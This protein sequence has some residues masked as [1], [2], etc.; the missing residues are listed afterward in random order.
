MK[1][2][3]SIAKRFLISGKFQTFMIVLGI[4]IGVSVQ[5][6][7]GSL[8]SGLQKSLVDKTI[9]SSSQIT[10]VSASPLSFISDYDEKIATIKSLDQPIDAI[11]PA[12][13]ASGSL[14]KNMI[15]NP[16]LIRGFDLTAAEEIYGFNEKLLLG[17]SLPDATGEIVVGIG[18]RDSLDLSIGDTI[19]FGSE[20][21][22]STSLEIVGFMDFNVLQLNSLWGIA[23]L[24][25]MQGI[26]GIGNQ[27]SKIEMQVSDV[28]AA[29]EID[30]AIMTALN[31]DSLESQNWKAQNAELLS[32]LQGQS[33]SSIMIQVFVM[34]SV[35]LAIAS[36]L[37][38]TVMQKSKQIG[39]LKAMGIQDQDA[40]LVFLFEGLILGLFGAVAGVLLG[41]GLSYAFTTFAVN[42]LGEP[43]VPLYIDFGFIALSALIAILASAGAALIPA[44]KSAKLSVIEVIRNA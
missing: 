37:A 3:Y 9:G 6:F 23:T 17:G 36:V 8:I 14:V 11:A 44:R 38:I 35:V 27:I 12:L 22:A 21:L 15:E 42:D 26:I 20:T 1:L 13:E 10:I 2:A 29:D 4:A 16:V 30:F 25:T 24:E 41:L 33:I 5:V 43:V 31:D 18:L 32:G 7:I 39:I 34:I 28:F 19:S 40:S